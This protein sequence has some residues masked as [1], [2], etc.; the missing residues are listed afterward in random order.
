MR[1]GV[2]SEI[3]G[4]A[5]ATRVRARNADHSPLSRYNLAQVASVL[6]VTLGVVLTTLSAST[7]RTKAQ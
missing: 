3:P 4:R 2:D 7:P 5:F 1:V 6:V